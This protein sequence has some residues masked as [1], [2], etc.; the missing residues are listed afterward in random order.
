MRH[1]GQ[2]GCLARL[3]KSLQ[4]LSRVDA[5]LRLRHPNVNKP[6]LL[7]LTFLCFSAVRADDVAFFY[8]LDADFGALQKQGSVLRQPVKI[9]QR[10]VQVLS[11]G[12]HKVYAIKMGSGAVETATSAQALIAR[13]RCD[14]AYS[15]GP[16]GGLADTLPVGSWH[17]V[18]QA[19]AYQRGS[20]TTSGF[21]LNKAAIINFDLPAQSGDLPELFRNAGPIT[22]ASGEIFVN[23]NSYREQLRE[24][25]GAEAVD[26]NL[27][28]LTTVCADHRIPLVNWRIISDK[29]DDNAGED[30]RKFT[31]SYK[32]EGGTALAELIKNLP[33]NP[34]SPQSYPE[35]EKLLREE[36]N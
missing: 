36:K 34:N 22:V 17:W 24:T 18:K 19:T 4:S 20:W 6:L 33:P 23:S 3:L 31:E 25:S 7:S 1:N 21:Q 11:L 2:G 5:L 15:L 32:G 9:G 8:A 30:F 29:A 28:G 14:R 26:M 13:F 16:V 12:K 27:F 10:A 35:L